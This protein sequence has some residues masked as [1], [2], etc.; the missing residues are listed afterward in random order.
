MD[1]P[2]K[3]PANPHRVAVIVPPNAVPLDVAVPLQ[4]FGPWPERMLQT[5]G[6]ACTPYSVDVAVVGDPGL[7]AR[8]TIE[9]A[10]IVE[11]DTV[12]VTGVLDPTA[13]TPAE[14]VAALQD[15]YS[16][17]ARIISICTGA[18]ALGDAGL[19]DEK[20]ATTHWMWAAEFRV[21]FPRA[22]L[23]EEDL[24]V[25][26]GQIATSAG[27]LAGTD[28]ALHIVARDLGRHVSNTLARF[29]VSPPHRD[30]GQAQYIRHDQTHT[31]A[32]M[33]A[34]TKWIHA[35]L[36]QPLTLEVIA[37]ETH[38]ST[39]TLSRWFRREAGSSVMDWV[40]RQRVVLACEMLETT[41]LPHAAVAYACGFGTPESFRTRFH[42]VM[43]TTPGAYRRT[44]NSPL[45]G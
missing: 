13:P 33:A 2:T 45:A 29:L 6:L 32:G 39:R 14:L 26:T 25:D 21:R 8:P 27:V 28:L 5:L 38:V 37:G 40:A 31:H 22:V 36:D 12:V 41:D 7:G 15:A 42:A 4:A 11:M 16:A 34:V 3:I 20:P 10:Q 23:R 43:G 1:M 44:F 19:L 35:H 30:G 18:F 9:I 24:Y 17:G